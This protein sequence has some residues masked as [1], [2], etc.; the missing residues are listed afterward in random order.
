M[1][2]D[3]K[4]GVWWAF[5]GVLGFSFTV[6][7]TRVAVGANGL[8]P[9]FIGAGRSVIAAV[10]ALIVLRA[11]RQRLPRK[12]E[13]PSLVIVA[14]GAV[15]GFPLLTSYALTK[16]PANHGA[17]VIAILPATTA[18]VAA[19]RTK[20]YPPRL[21]WIATTLGALGAIFFAASHSG[22]SLTLGKEDVL[23]LLAVVLCALG[24]AEGGVVSK[25]IGSWQS[26]SWALLIA[27]P[28]TAPLTLLSAFNL[29]QQP[30]LSQLLAIVYLSFVSMYLA[31]FAWYRGL[32]TGSMPQVSQIQL[33]QPVFSLLW[34]ALLLSESITGGTLLC[35]LFVVTCSLV[36]I[37]SKNSTKTIGE[38]TEQ[39]QGG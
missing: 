19:L 25:T 36:A 38:K 20:T 8:P 30:S 5:L 13:L 11:T 32:A 18:I 23:L 6:P 39:T 34:S 4:T 26:I 17:V 29:S 12:S 27:L 7:L 24:Y 14:I 22:G 9:L 37:R 3:S 2:E 35:A 33:T 16:V 28:I 15:L 1:Q 10:L 21:F 31:F